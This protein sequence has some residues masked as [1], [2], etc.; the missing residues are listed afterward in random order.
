M[1]YFWICSLYLINLLN[2]KEF[3]CISQIWTASDSNNRIKWVQKW[4]S[5]YRVR[6]EALPGKWKEIPKIFDNECVA[7][8][9]LNPKKKKT[10]Y[11]NHEICQDLMISYVEAVV[12]NWEGFAQSVMY[13][14]YKPKFLKKKNHSVE[15]DSA[16]FEVKVTIELRFDFK[17]FV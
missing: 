10:K 16:R 15:K 11:E 8:W 5:C 6:C 17:T 7:E 9:F 3:F 2:F 13:D 4:Y 1:V 14:V 12:K